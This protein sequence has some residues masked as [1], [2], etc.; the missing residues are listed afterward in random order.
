MPSPD[1][2]RQSHQPAGTTRGNCGGLP[3]RRHCL[4]LRQW[5]QY[6]PRSATHGFYIEHRLTKL[7]QLGVL[8]FQRLQ[9]LDV[10]DLHPAELGLPAVERCVT[11]A[12]L[13]AQFL[14]WYPL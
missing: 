14:D 13:A 4:A 11:E 5:G 8:R 9:P 6:F 12:V 2:Y 3:H 7:L 10:V 1:A